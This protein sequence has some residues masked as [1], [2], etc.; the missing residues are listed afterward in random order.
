MIKPM[1]RVFV[2]LLL[3]STS[4]WGQT[5]EQSAADMSPVGPAQLFQITVQC[6]SQRLHSIESKLTGD[7]RRIEKYD[8][9]LF[10]RFK[11]NSLVTA[12]I[13]G[14]HPMPASVKQCIIKNYLASPSFQPPASGLVPIHVAFPVLI[15][16][17]KHH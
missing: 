10:M 15:T 5:P 4:A 1:A 13:T 11:D 14:E 3:V 17:K 8:Y 12:V 9:T 2:L 16:P 6:D 7:Q